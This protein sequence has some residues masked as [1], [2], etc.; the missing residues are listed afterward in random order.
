MADVSQDLLWHGR[1]LCRA[2]DRAGTAERRL[3]DLAA[4]S[5][6]LL[7]ALVDY[8]GPPPSRPVSS[9]LLVDVDTARV[10][11]AGLLAAQDTPE[12]PRTAEGSPDV[13]GVP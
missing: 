1:A 9:D 4:A 3:A 6:A 5:E 8:H 13:L 11:L 2:L 10:A 12:P 7:D